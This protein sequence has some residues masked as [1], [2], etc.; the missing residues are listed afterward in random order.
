MGFLGAAPPAV[1]GLADLKFEDADEGI[2]FDFYDPGMG[3][4]ASIFRNLRD[5]LIEKEGKEKADSI[6]A[7]W[8]V[9]DIRQQAETESGEVESSAAFAAPR[10]KA[11]SKKSKKGEHGKEASMGV[12]KEK[13]KGLLSFMG[14]DVSKVPDDALP[15]DLPE[16]AGGK[17]FTEAELEAA[18]K[19]AEKEAKKTAESDFAEKEKEKLK[20]A[21]D[22][23]IEDFVEQGV[24][25]KKIL[26]SWK[27]AGLASFMQGLD[28]ETEVEFS[29]GG[30]KKTGLSWFK[31]F[32]EGF[33]KAPIFEEMAIKENAGEGHSV[34]AEN[35]TQHV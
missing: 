7:D 5:W 12:F 2:R 31:E 29:E 1:K 24:K 28:A 16:G 35:L 23:E 25:D 4:I 8:A 14:V 21:R 34:T 33:S 13:V 9:E 26:P 11:K 32:L 10:Q 17:M 15:D 3:V 27:D 22:K 19:Q 20:Q 18:K 30:G 6:I